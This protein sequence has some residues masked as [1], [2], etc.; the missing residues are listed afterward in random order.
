M[1]LFSNENNKDHNHQGI[2][3]LVIDVIDV[4]LDF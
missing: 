2:F 4:F 1:M 3:G